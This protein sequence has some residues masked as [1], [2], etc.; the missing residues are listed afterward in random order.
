M[1]QKITCAAGFRVSQLLSAGADP[2][3]SMPESETALLTAARTGKAEVVKAL[4]A[5]GANVNARDSYR[6]E[7]ALM[8][9]AGKNNVDAIRM[10]IEFGADLKLRTPNAV[11]PSG[12]EDV[13][14]D[15]RMPEPTSFTAFLFAVRGRHIGAAKALL[16]A[17]AN[18]NDK[19]S[20]GRSALVVACANGHWELAS[21]LVDR[22]ADPNMA[23]A[24]WNAASVDS[25]TPAQSLFR[26]SRTHR[27]R[28]DGEH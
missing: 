19:L 3:A 28:H 2:N 12:S 14:A 18:V 7:T 11:R 24:G 23:D 26:N 4:L 20:D 9:A 10:L 17:G 8:W 15:H 27:T 22:G 21:L 16:E 25:G 5:R 13:G 6:G 1:V